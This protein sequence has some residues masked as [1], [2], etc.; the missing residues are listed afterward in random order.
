MARRLV[1]QA[2]VVELAV[3]IAAGL[4]WG[5]VNVPE[6]NVLALAT[7]Q[8]KYVALMYANIGRSRR[9]ARRSS[10]CVVRKALRS[11][12]AATSLRRLPCSRRMRM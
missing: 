4:F 12:S 5:L 10:S 2:A 3:V 11:S 6:S 7:G 9:V 8:A 1:L